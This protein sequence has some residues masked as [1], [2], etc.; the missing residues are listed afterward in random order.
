MIKGCKRN[1]IM[2]KETGSRYFDS[3]Y[4]VLRCD[5][6]NSSREADMVAE[7]QRMIAAYEPGI[8]AAMDTAKKRPRVS[9]PWIA[10]ASLSVL[11]VGAALL[12]LILF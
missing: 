10:A 8:P 3:A 1:I 4:F 6:P 11:I 9:A 7:A 5:L 12:C 2:V